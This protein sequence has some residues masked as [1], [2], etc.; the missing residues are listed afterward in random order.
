M[1]E[2]KIGSLDEVQSADE[3]RRSLQE[4]QLKKAEADAR[5]R[6]AQES[7]LGAFTD[8]FLKHHVTDEEIARVRRV[9]SAAV[10]DGKLEAMV[11]S[12]PSS[13]C[14]DH[15]RAI[16]NGDKDWPRNSTS[17]TSASAAPA[18]IS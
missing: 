9:V 4:E 13:L 1:P 10:K 16:N 8:D 6:A 14:S 15:G 12:F 11:Y 17:A 3:L 2:D 7:E 5:K 18:A